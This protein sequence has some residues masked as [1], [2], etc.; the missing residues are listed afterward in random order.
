[1]MLASDGGFNMDSHVTKNTLKTLYGLAMLLA[2]SAGL[3]LPLYA[4]VVTVSVQGRVYDPTG[5]AIPG[6]NIAVVNIETG[7]SRSM[8]ATA[9]GDYQFSAL[10]VGDYTI[11]AEKA[12][13]HKSAKKVRLEVGAE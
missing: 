7:F 4:Q 3:M 10:P 1:M 6:A 11:T 8:T 13:F 2:V 5:A 9:G 12:G